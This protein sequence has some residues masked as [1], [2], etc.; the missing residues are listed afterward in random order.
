MDWA[1]DR[2][3][4]L[5]GR[6]RDVRRKAHGKADR[7]LVV[8]VEVPA[9]AG[10]MHSVTDRLRHSRHRV[11]VSTVRMRPQGKFANVEDAIRAA[12]DPL[13]TYDW[14]VITDDDVGLSDRF[15]DDYLAL[16]RHCDLAISQPAHRFA[17]Y[18]SYE[19]TRRRLGSLVRSTRF[20]EIGPLTVL[21]AVTFSKL[22]PFPPSRWCWGIDALWSH[23][24][25]R[26][27]W[28]MGIVDAV[29]VGHLRPI[30]AS[31]DNDDA[32]REAEGLLESLGVPMP[33]QEI[34][35]SA[36]LLKV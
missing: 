36:P 9:R 24:A 10:D 35:T 15:L 27:G 3:L 8:G 16:A 12:P 13:E 6:F 18:A 33:G 25:E 5:S 2:T 1:A 34:L 7:V 26:E 29:P 31:Y 21:S 28:T 4:G 23:L 32:V 14:L 17:S 22:I 20:V 19:I 11:D 30:A